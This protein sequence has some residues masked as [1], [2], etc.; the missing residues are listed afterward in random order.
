MRSLF[1]D[2]WTFVKTAPGT[3]YEQVHSSTYEFCPVCIPHDWAIESFS[4]FYEDAT[5]WYR[6]VLDI[7]KM[8][9]GR[10]MLYFDG[11]YMDSTIYVNGHQIYEWKYGYTQFEVD[12]TSYIKPGD[13]ELCVSVNYYNP[14]SRWYSGAGITR[15]VWIDTVP[16]I[17]IP[18]YGIYA[19][20]DKCDNGNDWILTVDTT[21]LAADKSASDNGTDIDDIMNNIQIALV[22]EDGEE[23]TIDHTGCSYCEP[24]S[25]YD[26]DNETVIRNT[27][28]VRGPHIW[29]I[30]SPYVYIIK[31]T[32]PTGSVQQ[33][34]FGFRTIEF[35]TDKGAFLNG[36]HIKL[37]GVCEHHDFGMLGGVFYE[38]A[39]ERK[40][41][42]LKNMGVNAIRF[43]HNPVD[44]ACLT[45]CNRLGMLV[46]SEAF[47]MWEKS[48]TTYD[49][50]RFFGKWHVKDI[51]SW[52]KQDRNAPSLIMWSIGNEIYDIHA[53][54]RGRELVN[55]LS[56]LVR[57]YD[58]LHNG[59]ITFCSNYMPWENAQK[60]AED[61]EVVGYNYAEKY[62]EEH[63]KEHPDWIIY[64]S[65][66]S[67]IT[68][69][70]GVYHFP[71]SATILSDDDLQCSVMGNS[72][73]SWGAN[74]IEECVC[75]DRDTEFS[76]GQFIWSGHDYLGE[77]TPYHTKNS[78]LGIIDTAGYPKDP[79]YGWKSSF[80]RGQ[81]AEPFIYVSPE[82]DYNEGQT[83]DIRVYSSADEVEVFVNGRSLG[84]QALTHDAG[85]GYKIVA[86]YQAEYESGELTAVG[87]DADGNEIVRTTRKSFGDAV[88]AVCT[89]ERFC[90]NGRQHE[91]SRYAQYGRRLEFYDITATDIDG[92]VVEN[93]SCKVRVTVSGNGRL[94]A[95][96]NGDSTDY[97]PQGSD[98]KALFKGKLLAVVEKYGDEEVDVTASICKDDVPVRKIELTRQGGRVLDADNNTVKVSSLIKPCDATDQNIIYKIT[99]NNGNDS[100]IANIEKIQDGEL[101]I[102]ALGDGCFNLRAFSKSSSEGVRVISQLDFAAQ[103]LGSAYYSPYVLVPGSCYCGVI[104]TAGTGNERGA[105]TARGQET[106]LIYEGIDFGPRGSELMTIPIFSLDNQ[107]VY[108]DIYDGVYGQEDC[109]CICN[110]VYDHPSIWNV[111]QE[112]TFKLNTRLTGVH[113]ICF[114]T[115]EKM[116]I[117]GFI[118]KEYNPIYDCMDINDAQNIYGD[119]YAIEDDMVA[120]I[121]NNVTIDFGEIDCT[122]DEPVNITICGRAHG[123]RNTLH[124]RFSQDGEQVR[125]I[126]EFDPT[127]EIIEK[128]FEI[129][130]ISGKGNLQLIFLPGCDFDYKWMKF[131]FKKEN[132]K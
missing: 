9:E 3:T 19:H 22:N 73:T 74:S 56:E 80:T 57:K 59:Y 117:K 18:R 69:S 7:E 124:L 55:E 123:D 14:N 102:K 48:K 100:N 64:G 46:M 32:L 75:Y 60:A 129:N 93:A 61:I 58:R 132:E 104:G 36:R 111:Y 23:L 118:C 67:S 1:I 13:N 26:S 107:V 25:E 34:E 70:R 85:T 72:V 125:N 82:W 127:E 121:G 35:T 62:Y 4:T 88:N 68:Y 63:H 53:G 96:D 92:N 30:D 131:G 91:L 86:D 31:A 49:Y 113:T 105:A 21:V 109:K 122:E 99:D 29:D 77:P 108:I 71:F 112:E 89:K 97:T 78:Y 24:Y 83:I 79:Y 15:N 115:Y 28:V 110:G 5:G 119:T 42:N 84:R 54:E 81:G 8:P 106:V 27:F 47:D 33:T 45:L 94:L 65:E 6:K 95:L 11:I 43:A 52:V 114:K 120:G 17:H 12:I 128:T 10:M 44:P 101:T 116:H 126:A 39:M 87:Y 38:D 130:G 76:L 41:I 50:A 2:G 40:I 90:L 98:V 66:T 20:A 16:V 51:M 103:D 37:N